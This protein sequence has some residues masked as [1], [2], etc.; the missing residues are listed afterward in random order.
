MMIDTPASAALTKNSFVVVS[1]KYIANISIDTMMWYSR[2]ITAVIPYSQTDNKDSLCSNYC[3]D[4]RDN[5]EYQ[6]YDYRQHQQYK[7]IVEI[8]SEQCCVLQSCKPIGQHA[9]RCHL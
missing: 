9:C 4:F 2:N 7:S 1:L 3:L 8:V 6:S 5:E